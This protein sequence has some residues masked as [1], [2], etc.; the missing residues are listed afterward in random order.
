[1]NLSPHF[2][3]EEM[4]HSDTAKRRGWSNIPED[5]DA[6]NLLVLCNT[7]LEPIRDLLGTP[8][9]INSGYR[10][11]QLN[12]AV[13]GVLRSA[14]MEG[15]AADFVTP[16]MDLNLAF[17]KITGS[18]MQWDQLIWEWNKAGSQW[19]HIAVARDGEKPRQQVLKMQHRPQR[20]AI[21]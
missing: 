14:H 16:G 21:S 9:K 4:T 15:R 12:A 6:Q 13:G 20:R 8:L 19:I 1:M 2:T 18:K 10:S 7:L 11:P 3:L 5:S 17:D